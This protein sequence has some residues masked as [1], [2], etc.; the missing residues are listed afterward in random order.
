MSVYLR[1]RERSSMYP[2]TAKPAAITSRRI[3]PHALRLMKLWLMASKM[4]P[5]A[6]AKY[7]QAKRRGFTRMAED[8]LLQFAKLF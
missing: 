4:Y 7:H 2:S 1:A 8:W 6:M 5:S 3:T